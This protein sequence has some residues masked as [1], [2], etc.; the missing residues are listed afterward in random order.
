L[1]KSPSITS[2]Q[3]RSGTRSKMTVETS[4]SD[5]A[6]ADCTSTPTVVVT[7]TTESGVEVRRADGAEDGRGVG[8]SDVRRV[9]ENVSAGVLVGLGVGT[10]V[11]LPVEL[12]VVG[13]AV[14]TPVGTDDPVPH[15]ASR[16]LPSK[17]PAGP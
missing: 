7:R 6:A 11:G 17:V 13:F 5:G 9:G 1:K 4:S 16:T 2:R 8:A 12:I 10:D 14:G 15:E 3:N